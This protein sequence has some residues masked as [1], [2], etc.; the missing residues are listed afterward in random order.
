VSDTVQVPAGTT[1]EVRFVAG[2]PGTYQYSGVVGGGAGDASATMDAELH[3]AFV[4]DARNAPRVANE[5]VLVIGLWT[6]A[7]RVGGQISRND[8][9]RFTINGK[10]WPYTERLA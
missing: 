10:A 1:R 5:R 9:L 2:V 7:P 8:L 6:R 3:G 4:V